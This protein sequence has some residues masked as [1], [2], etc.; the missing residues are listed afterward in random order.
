MTS[1]C[2]IPTGSKS[3]SCGSAR[4]SS[5]PGRQHGSSGTTER[6]SDHQGLAPNG[7]EPRARRSA[8]WYRSE[9][10]SAV[11]RRLGRAEPVIR[12]GTRPHSPRRG[13]CA[14][15][16][17]G[18]ARPLTAR[19]PDRLRG[20][21][22]RGRS[23]AIRLTTPVW[24]CIEV[25]ELVAVHNKPCPIRKVDEAVSVGA[26]SVGERT[27]IY[28]PEPVASRRAGASK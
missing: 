3:C 23:S 19:S 17:P 1:Q 26:E 25:Q 11:A 8:R 7:S 15:P 21:R 9:F 13:L 22:L 28:A 14:G 18:R 12:A 24:A 27:G 10:A 5:P 6:T 2:T 4:K 16:Q 20:G